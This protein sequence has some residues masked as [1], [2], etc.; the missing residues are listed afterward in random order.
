MNNENMD[1][2][3]N[4]E[5]LARLRNAVKSE[6][7]PPELQV[8]VRRRIDA[9]TAPPRFGWRNTWVPAAAMLVVCAGAAVLYQVGR[10]RGTV[11][12][13]ES[14]IASTLQSVATP[15]KPG[16]DDHIHCSHYGRVPKTL[17]G[18]EEAT[19]ALP[20]KYGSLLQVV[21]NRAPGEFR[22]Y[23]AH[24][25]KRGGRQF[26]HFQLKS[27]RRLLSVIVVRKEARESF[28]RHN[29]A[30]SV[31]ASGI[32]VYS[33]GSRQFQ[34]AAIES[35]EYMAYVVSDLPAEQNTRAMLAMAR[36]VSEILAA[37]K[38]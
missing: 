17:P 10:L 37:W 3:M 13:Q 9:R 31:M 29:L 15:L 21:T 6:P 1:T 25:C 7:V 34:T 36:E 28:V 30:P 35:G 23:G 32:P 18:V 22:I 11:E 16:L 20:P 4:Q 12:D 26:V 5:M 2:G 8:K 33:A 38:S 27:S 14:F 19:K 24:L